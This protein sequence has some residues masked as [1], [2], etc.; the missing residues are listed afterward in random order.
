MSALL[1][2][3]TKLHTQTSTHSNINTLK[4]QQ[5]VLPRL[6]HRLVTSPK[7]DDDTNSKDVLK[8][9]S[10]L[11]QQKKI[12]KNEIESV[13]HALLILLDA[14]SDSLR[15]GAL[16]CLCALVK[17][18]DRVC[19]AVVKSGPKIESI[20]LNHL[21]SSSS[22]K[23]RLAMDLS[24]RLLNHKSQGKLFESEDSVM[25]L[26]ESSE[27]EPDVYVK[28]LSA[29]SADIVWS[30]IG[31]SASINTA[32]ALLL[33]SD[34][35]SSEAA[36]SAVRKMCEDQPQL[37][38]RNLKSGMPKVISLLSSS[39]SKLS[40]I[41]LVLA[42]TCVSEKESSEAMVGELP[43]LLRLLSSYVVTHT[44]SITDTDTNT[45]TNNTGTA[46]TFH[47]LH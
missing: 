39:Q 33:V 42:S 18:D 27:K 23:R 15:N 22:E 8:I 2:L 12:D 38:A 10:I 25:K 7:D 30:S 35:T 4:Q 11:R 24:L 14:P 37:V 9:C 36:L 17:V 46:Q 26:L 43:A 45:N 5:Q 19:G 28:L 29:L 47:P 13:T 6:L 16:Q 40:E 34:R 32:V 3:L 41:A 31:S 20:L 21:V 1:V 44:L